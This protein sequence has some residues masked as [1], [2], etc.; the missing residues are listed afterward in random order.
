LGEGALECADIHMHFTIEDLEESDVPRIETAAGLLHAAFSPRGAWTTMAEARQE[1]I[2]SLGSDRI[3]RVAVD[4]DGRVLGWIGAIPQ[5]DGLVWELHPIVVA[6]PE[7]RRGIGRALVLDLEKILA[8]RGAVT[9]W[10]G[11]DDLSGE[12]SLGGIDLYATLPSALNRVRSWGSHPLPFYYR[13][14]FRVI[15]VMP[16]A[17]GAGRPDIFLGKRLGTELTSDEQ[18]SD[19]YE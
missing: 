8:A 9:L 7:R 2:D 4:T 19:S 18:T 13:L 15:G 17:N 12:T 3:S 16:D 10:T 5:Y 14:G 1:V 6:D 11:A